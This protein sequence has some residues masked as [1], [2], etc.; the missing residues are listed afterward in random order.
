MIY[1]SQK[2]KYALIYVDQE[3]IDSI[4]E[5]LKKLSFVSK[6]SRSQ[7]PFIRTNYEK[8]KTDKDKKYD[9]NMGV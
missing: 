9:Y 2:L 4:E 1:T 8:V 7:K 3:K 6:I 5:K